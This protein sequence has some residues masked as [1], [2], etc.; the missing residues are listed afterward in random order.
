MSMKDQALIAI[1]FLKGAGFFLL[2]IA[3]IVSRRRALRTWPKVVASVTDT[4][5]DED[6]HRRVTLVYS[7]ASGQKH[8]TQVGGSNTLGLG[9]EVMV[10]HNPRNPDQ[11][12]IAGD[13]E[14]SLRTYVPVVV[15]GVLLVVAYCLI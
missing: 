2:G 3:L 12:Y 7:T 8:R 10:V 13:G 9:S 6:G 14:I 1:L 4:R 11:V 15:G 5:Y